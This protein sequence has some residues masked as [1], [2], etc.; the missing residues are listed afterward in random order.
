MFPN[1]HV[2]DLIFFL[3]EPM[4]GGEGECYHPY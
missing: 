1:F 2:S 3:M 4:R